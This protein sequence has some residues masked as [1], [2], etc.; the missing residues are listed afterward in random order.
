MHCNLRQLCQVHFF[1]HQPLPGGHCPCATVVGTT[2]LR[3]DATD[4][5]TLGLAACGMIAAHELFICII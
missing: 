5:A 2:L 1:P 3:T 4:G